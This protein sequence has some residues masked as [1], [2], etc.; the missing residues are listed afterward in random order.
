MSGEILL[1]AILWLCALTCFALACARRKRV[2]VLP[3]LFIVLFV[4]FFA[5][6]SPSGK[7]LITI[8]RFRITLDSL[9]LGLRRSGM[10]VGMVFLSRAIVSPDM[11]LH[12]TIG[13]KLTDVFYWLNLLTEKRIPLKRGHIIEAIDERLFEIWMADAAAA[14]PAAPENPEV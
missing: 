4:T 8:G 12:G 6:L 7:V 3:P 14:P 11:R 2:R 10:L 5:L 9:L 1:T 13:S